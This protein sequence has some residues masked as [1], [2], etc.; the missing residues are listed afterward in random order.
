MKILSTLQLLRITPLRGSHTWVIVAA[1]LDCFNES[2][3]AVWVCFRGLNKVCEE[4]SHWPVRSVRTE[5]PPQ[6]GSGE[7]GLNIVCAV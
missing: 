2:K 5:L 3:K 7:P 1:L 6:Q 4:S